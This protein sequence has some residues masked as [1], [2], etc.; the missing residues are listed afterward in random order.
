MKHHWQGFTTLEMLG[1]L[2][3]GAMMLAGLA[4]MV[5]SSLEDAKAQQAAYYQSQV[6]DAATKYIKLNYGTLAVAANVNKTTAIPLDTL[7]TAKLLS[8]GFGSANA[9]GQVPCLLVRTRSNAAGATPAYLLDALVVTEG[10]AAQAIPEANLFSAAG[11]SGSGGG[12]ISAQTPSAAAGV[13]GSWKIDGTT[14]PALADFLSTRCSANAAGAG[15][16]ASAIFYDGPGQLSTDFV[17]RNAVTGHPEF[18]RMNTPLRLS[19]SAIVNENDMCGADAAIAVDA[20]KNL[21][22]CDASGVWKRVTT[23]KQPV[24][25]YDFLPGVATDA[26]DKVGDVRMTLDSG[27]A[28]MYTGGGN[29]S[30]L[31]V[32]QNGDLSVPRH[33]EA[34]NGNILAQTGNIVA[35]GGD[36]VA[37]RD[38]HVMGE[39][40]FDQDIQAGRD[41]YSQGNV[42]AAYDLTA[43]AVYAVRNLNAGNDINAGERL[44][45][46]Y[47]F[48]GGVTGGA[49][50]VTGP[51]VASGEIITGENLIQYNGEN[52]DDLQARY[53]NFSRFPSYTR[54]DGLPPDYIQKVQ[55][56]IQH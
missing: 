43:N 41:I 55:G 34:R 28:F 35:N 6:V 5:Q 45:G 16:L 27:R 9:Y 26:T 21:M 17:Y 48:I 23:W 2:A 47:L 33:I 3:V 56:R 1:T 31:A 49:A 10:T 24:A 36:L 19:A 29:W 46:K 13:Y 25:T 40:Y 42:N 37:G 11:A 18:N 15:S 32:D 44:Q 39:G 54:N 22:N 50:F 20:S 38:L 53:A 8:P 30:A 14:T 4:A 51:V 12:A 7:I 52:S